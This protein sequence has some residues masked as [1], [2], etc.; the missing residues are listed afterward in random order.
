M[1]QLCPA[2]LRSSTRDPLR[3]PCAEQLPAPRDPLEVAPGDSALRL[4]RARPIA[5]R[6]W[7]VATSVDGSRNPRD[8]GFTPERVQECIR[9]KGSIVVVR[10]AYPPP[11]LSNGSPANSAHEC[12]VLEWLTSPAE[13]VTTLKVDDRAYRR[14][15]N[16]LPAQSPVEGERP[17]M[18]YG[19]YCFAM[20]VSGGGDSRQLSA[21]MTLTASDDL[22]IDEIRKTV[23]EAQRIAAEVK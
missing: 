17:S 12:R 7:I 9:T 1:D 19:P 10:A 4:R 21:L 20:M 11:S 13:P 2:R 14:L 15:V 22:A 5:N 16:G 18:I 3:P 6:E 8:H 23:T